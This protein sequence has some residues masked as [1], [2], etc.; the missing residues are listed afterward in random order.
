MMKTIHY[1]LLITTFL[2]GFAA[3][4]EDEEVAM[5]QLKVTATVQAECQS[6]KITCTT[7]LQGSAVSYVALQY[8]TNSNFTDA[9]SKMGMGKLNDGAYVL[10]LSDLQPN[11]KYYVRFIVENTVTS[12]TARDIFFFNTTQPSLPSLLPLSV[13]RVSQNSA[14]L[15]C[16]VS[17][18][19]G[20]PIQGREFYYKTRSS[21]SWT[22]VYPTSSGS[23][24]FAADITLSA[25]ND[26]EAYAVAWNSYGSSETEI[27][28]FSTPAQRSTPTVSTK[29]EQIAMYS[30]MMGGEV[31]SDGGDVVT[32][33]GVCYTSNSTTPTIN[34]SNRVM[35]GA[36]TDS[37]LQ[38]VENLQP[39]TT[40]RVR[41]YAINSIGVAYGS[42]IEITTNAQP[43][44]T[45]YEA[46]NITSTS[47]VVD[48][49]TSAASTARGLC[50][51]MHSEPDAY[52]DYAVENGSGSG[53][54]ACTM[55]G[56]RPGTTYYARAYA[57]SGTDVTYGNLIQFTTLTANPVVETTNVESISYNSATVNAAVTSDGGQTI[58][59][60]G[61]CY[62]TSGTPT[63]SNDK[64]TSGVGVGSYACQ[65]TGLNSSTTYYVRAYAKTAT[66][67]FYGSTLL[68]TTN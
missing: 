12:M 22:R 14:H 44:V 60:R 13:E 53:S 5:T 30:A 42:I 8:A 59:E 65:L 2:L 41:A 62:N 18:D 11:T 15:A 58:I 28:Y 36:G 25:G 21:S 50:W 3:C 43:S 55:S 46:Q 27:V 23:S 49:Y 10:N 16:A 51:A 29:V 52:N 9:S 47:A 38:L 31:S 57:I 56:L 33:Y 19:G 6:A 20:M 37:F 54:Y 7:N 64:V 17:Y 26:Y 67:I 66:G 39:N 68:F 24:L 61:V 32:E 4:H 63:V 34:S 40:Y 1:I 35:M 45:T 48:S